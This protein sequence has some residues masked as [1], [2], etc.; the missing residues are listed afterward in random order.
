MLSVKR[1]VRGLTEIQS[2]LDMALDRIPR[3]VVTQGVTASLFDYGW[4]TNLSHTW[5]FIDF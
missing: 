5:T 2:I 1:L 4:D 3:V